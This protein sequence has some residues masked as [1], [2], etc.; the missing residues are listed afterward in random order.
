MSPGELYQRKLTSAITA[1]G[2]VKSG[3]WID[4]GVG[5]SH[6]VAFD[7][8]L[9]A[10]A[11]DLREVKVRG[12]FTLW[13]PAIF[14][15]ENPGA[16]FCWNSW[17]FTAID[18]KI[19]EMGCG[20]HSPMS[21]FE[22]PR[23]YGENLEQISVAVCQVAPMDR[24]GN[25]SFGTSPAYQTAVF[26]QAAI[27]IVEVNRNMP[28]TKGSSD[29]DLHISQVDYVIE[30]SH[31]NVAEIIADPPDDIDRQV[32]DLIVAEIPDG[33]CLQLG[34]GR[35]PNAV[36]SLIAESDLTDLGVHTET[37]INAFMDIS[38]RGRINGSNKTID[39]GRQV[40]S[41]VLGSRQLYDFV[42]ENPDLMATTID[43]SNDPR[44]IARLDNF[45]SINNAVEIDLFG[46]V[47]AE[48]NGLKQISGTG[49]Y[50]GFVIGAYWSKGGK[51]IVCLAST[52]GRS[53]QRKSRV[54]PTLSSGTITTGH[55][56]LTHLVVTEFGKANLKGMSTWQRAEALIG[57]AHPDYREDL[58]SD[59]ARMGIWRRS[60]K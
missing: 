36:G 10:R 18:R 56:T 44:I 5:A 21:F 17:H 13:M 43:Y 38:K 8:A 33:A 4:Y 31:G 2:L 42:H 37:Y 23:Y 30:G 45:I 57:L 34:I 29:V 1:A 28:R 27:R 59:A 48:S 9:A 51:S 55:R 39:R 41:Y 47:S 12:A 20:F 19:M 6:P 49:G 40:Y 46:Q 25:F 3:D 35:M 22:L 24:D 14:Q 60:N 11:Q 53:Q 7:Q 26:A 54:V 58:I 15:I 52:Y 16:H 50:L 32:A